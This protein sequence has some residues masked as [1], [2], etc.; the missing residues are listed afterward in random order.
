[1]FLTKNKRMSYGYGTD[2][3]WCPESSE[4]IKS[5]VMDWEADEFEVALFLAGREVSTPGYSRQPLIQRYQ[6]A[7]SDGEH[8]DAADACFGI[9]VSIIAD[10]AII[11]HLRGR[12]KTPLM[13]FNFA[14]AQSWNGAFIIAWGERG[15]FIQD[16]KGLRFISGAGSDAKATEKTK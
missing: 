4:Y 12:D 11:Y 13:R 14:R 5:T 9:D 6:W 2:S 10:R 16:E 7:E 8:F 1:M 15:I 3:G